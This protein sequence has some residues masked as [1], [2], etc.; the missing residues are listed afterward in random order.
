[1][2]GINVNQNQTP[3]ENPTVQAQAQNSNNETTRTL[4]QQHTKTAMVT[5]A[6]SGIVAVLI[7]ALLTASGAALTA[8]VLVPLIAIGVGLLSCWLI[9]SPGKDQFTQQPAQQN[10]TTTQQNSTPQGPSPEEPQPPNSPAGP[11]KKDF[12]GLSKT[13]VKTQDFYNGKDVSTQTEE[14]II[15]EEKVE[16]SDT[17]TQEVLEASTLTPN[18]TEEINLRG[19]NEYFETLRKFLSGGKEISDSDV[20]DAIDYLTNEQDFIRKNLSNGEIYS[21][22]KDL[23]SALT[24][25]REKKINSDLLERIELL[26]NSINPG[27][28]LSVVRTAEI[29]TKNFQETLVKS[30][31]KNLK[32][33]TSKI[34]FLEEEIKST[35]KGIQKTL[36]EHDEK[37]KNLIDALNARVSNMEDKIKNLSDDTETQKTQIG[38]LIPEITALKEEINNSAQAKNQQFDAIKNSITALQNELLGLQ[39]K[40]KAISDLEKKKLEKQVEQLQQQLQQQEETIGD[41]KKQNATLQQEKVQ[42]TEQIQELQ[43]QIQTNQEE[44]TQRKQEIEQLQQL[45]NDLNANTTENKQE[46]ENKE[47]EI[48]KLEEENQQLI[49]KVNKLSQQLNESETQMQKLQKIIEANNA[50]INQN[51]RKIQELEA[52]KNNLNTNAATNSQQLG[53]KQN[54]IDQLNEQILGLTKEIE[55]LKKDNAE[56][57]GQINVPKEDVGVQPEE[58]KFS[59]TE[60]QTQKITNTVKEPVAENIQSDEV[61]TTSSNDNSEEKYIEDTKTDLHNKLL[62][63][64]DYIG[65][66]EQIETILNRAKENLLNNA[67][68]KAAIGAAATGTN[69][70][71][72]DYVSYNPTVTELKNDF[73]HLNTEGLQAAYIILRAE[74]AGDDINT[75]AKILKPVIDNP[76]KPPPNGIEA[77]YP[78]GIAELVLNKLG[79]AIKKLD[80]DRIRVSVENNNTRLYTTEEL[81]VL[82]RLKKSDTTQEKLRTLLV[83]EE[84]LRKEIKETSNDD[85]K[86][87]ANIQKHACLLAAIAPTN[88]AINLYKTYFTKIFLG[89]ETIHKNE[90]SH[91]KKLKEVVEWLKAAKP[92]Y[93]DPGNKLYVPP[94]KF[95]A[96]TNSTH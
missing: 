10:P 8:V 7:G 86:R 59:I 2:S 33:F 84:K 50:T 46:L 77:P 60:T 52:E 94:P 81:D 40:Q 29:N 15:T 17:Q 32:E 13:G 18:A 23:E 78:K 35:L 58:A 37:L 47:K 42:Q 88:A 36:E 54:R 72:K 85:K 28:L 56:L 89:T 9:L 90:R 68:L 4:M 83:W 25:A 43:K 45:Q 76:L 75:L 6:S 82:K 14:N 69:P 87:K 30:V 38:K 34:L 96:E 55:R 3:G 48:Q 61:K 92:Y 24:K 74:V 11:N 1:M 53:E 12:N 95:I 21:S 49:G 5:V 64:Q 27:Y 26:V 93:E 19:V 20:S 51:K 39:Q 67:L 22:F 16:N 57:N 71:I 31:D 80:E 73:F 63:H 65:L 91:A 79:N 66:A 41:L 62:K 70:F 44:I